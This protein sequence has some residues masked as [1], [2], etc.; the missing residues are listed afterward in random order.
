MSL[1][2]LSAVSDRTGA[3]SRQ[4]RHWITRGLITCERVPK[5]SKLWFYLDETEAEVVRIMAILIEAGITDI[6]VACTVARSRLRDVALLVEMGYAGDSISTE[7]TL[8]PG[9]VITIS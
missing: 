6:D 2:E 1:T 3:T 5:G 8:K 4:I 7:H 9:V